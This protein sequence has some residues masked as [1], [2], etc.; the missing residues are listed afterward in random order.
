M[1]IGAAE[2][3]DLAALQIL[4]PFDGT[5]RLHGE[6]GRGMRAIRDQ[7]HRLQPR[8]RGDHLRQIALGG[9]IELAVGKGLVHRWTGALEEV[10]LDAD[11]GD[12]LQ[13]AL[14]IALGMRCR[15]RAATGELPVVDADIGEAEADHGRILGAHRRCGQRRWRQKP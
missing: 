13:L 10:E 9:E 7:L 11:A 1:A 8:R 6:E 15:R 4:D 3:G 14:E 2:D 5:V 12:V